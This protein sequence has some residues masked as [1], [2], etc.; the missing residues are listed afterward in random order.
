MR[1]N[2]RNFLKSAAAV[3]GSAMFVTNPTA[4]VPG[5]PYGNTV[6]QALAQ[7]VLASKPVEVFINSYTVGTFY[8]R[9]GIDVNQ[10]LDQCFAELKEAGLAGFEA[11]AGQPGE[12]DRVID[13]MAKQDLKL[14]S[15]YAGAN[16]HDAG[17]D[18]AEIKRV[19]AV[20][21]R[22]KS[23]GTKFVVFNPAAKGGKSDAELIRQ[24]KNLDLLGAALREMGMNLSMHYHT[25]ELEFAAREFHSF[26][27]D[28][29]PANVSLCMEVHWSYRASGNSAVSVYN[30]AKLYADRVST[31]HLRQ[32]QG[33]TWTETFVAKADIDCEKV[34]AILQANKGFDSNCHIVLEQAPENG[35]PKTLKPLEIFKQSAEAVKKMYEG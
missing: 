13:A 3:T 32:S 27:C 15:I 34:L 16:L 12:L 2:R 4:I 28:T 35:T 24:N 21:E 33:G 1:Q 10:N 11:S 26:M 30:H 8:A 5:T 18:A 25:S 22:A 7:T 6:P 31:M 29:D 14:R 9:E 20:A 23:A 19:I 17:T